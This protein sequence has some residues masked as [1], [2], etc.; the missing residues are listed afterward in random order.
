MA[1]KGI[2]VN[3]FSL[4]GT[5]SHTELCLVNRRDVE[6]RSCEFC[7]VQ[8]KPSF[9]RLGAKLTSEDIWIHKWF[10][11]MA[12]TKPTW[13]APRAA[14]WSLCSHYPATNQRAAPKLSP[15]QKNSNFF[16]QMKNHSHASRIPSFDQSPSCHSAEWKPPL[17]PCLTSKTCHD[18]GLRSYSPDAQMKMPIQRL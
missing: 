4:M 1:P 8:E 5:K 14:N 7:S 2:A 13:E 6:A 18:M 16:A 9:L 10:S 17:S 15:K 3:V 11:H 12:W